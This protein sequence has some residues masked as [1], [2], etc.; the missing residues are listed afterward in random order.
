MRAVHRYQWPE[1]SVVKK[2]PIK[3]R[4][5][6]ISEG[7]RLAWAAKKKPKKPKGTK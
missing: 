7:L 4:Q 2:I 6:R 3:E 5:R 1:L